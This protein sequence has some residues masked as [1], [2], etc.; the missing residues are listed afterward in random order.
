MGGGDAS[1]I[2]LPRGNPGFVLGIFMN[3]RAKEW[4]YFI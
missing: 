1:G 4:V 3:W 2:I